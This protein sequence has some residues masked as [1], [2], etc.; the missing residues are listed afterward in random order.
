MN[1]TVKLIISLV[2]I[3]TVLGGVFYGLNR[4]RQIPDNPPT[5][6]GNLAGNLYNQGLFCEEDGVVYFSNPYDGGAMY[7]MNPSETEIKKLL[8]YSCKWINAE[9]D[10][11]YYYQSTDGADA[12]AGFGGHM[13]GVFRSKKDGSRTKCLDKTLSGTIALAGNN[14]YYQHYTN[15][16]KEG[17]TL[18]KI[19]IDKK[20]YAQ[21]SKDIIDPSCVQNG[22]IY[23][24]GTNGDHS[25]YYLDTTRD[26]IIPLTSQV[27][28]YNPLVAEDGNT[29][30]YMNV[31]DNYSLHKY[32][33]SSGEDVKLTGDRV[34]CFNMTGDYIFYQKND[35]EA[36]AL[37]RMR[38]DG[39]EAEIVAEGNYTAI[40]VTS[41]FVY[42]MRFGED[43]RMF[44]APIY[45]PVSVSDFGAASAAVVE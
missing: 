3:V 23:F 8:K 37:M 2:L 39:S 10:Y 44:H 12:I 17:M 32:I 45:G 19:G 7:V 5:A 15:V 41:Q 35:K 24:S 14:L 16:N 22:N 20:E 25:L 40:N 34:D 36:P 29:V 31:M 26:E 33:L 1:S 6:T 21:I 18:Y 38:L 30:Y 28:F 43:Y 27:P 13:M 42:F 11:L 4:M 9:G